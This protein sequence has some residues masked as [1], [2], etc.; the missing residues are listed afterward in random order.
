MVKGRFMVVRRCKDGGEERG[1]EER[2]WKRRGGEERGGEE[3]EAVWLL[4]AM[5]QVLYA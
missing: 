3:R 5:P 2:R 1:G 4:H